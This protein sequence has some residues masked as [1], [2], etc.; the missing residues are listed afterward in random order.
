[1]DGLMP[2]ETSVSLQHYIY[3]ETTGL[4]LRHPLLTVSPYSEQ[5]KAIYT[6]QLQD[7]FREL[8]RAKQT[9]NWAKLIWL[10]EPRYRG[11]ALWQ[12]ASLM[13][14]SQYW[15]MVAEVWINS[16]DRLLMQEVWTQLWSSSRPHREQAMT[17]YEHDAL[18]LL[19]ESE[20][21]YITIYRGYCDPSALY[22][23]SWAVSRTQ[24]LEFAHL[25][26]GPQGTPLLAIGQVRKRDIKAHFVDRKPGEAEVVVLPMDCQ[27]VTVEVLQRVA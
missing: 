27:A 1:M 17:D 23:M 9:R 24:A 8:R 14:D 22:G 7:K 13:T 12:I 2:T 26:A 11:D 6:R 19:P 3:Q 10:H 15:R 5:K 4:V 25:Y 18:A 16:E 21:G 20:P